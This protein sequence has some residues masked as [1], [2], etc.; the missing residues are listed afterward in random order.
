MPILSEQPSHYPDDL[1][2]E[3]FAGHPGRQWWV[4]YTKVRQEKAVAR[5]FLKLRTPFY[6]P[7]VWKRSV[8]RGRVIRSQ[9]PLFPGYVF[10]Y[11]SEEE[12]VASLATNRIVRI[13]AV[14]APER[15]REDLS[16][17]RRLIASGAAVTL[18][19]RLEPG[20]RVRVRHGPFVGIEGTVLTR[21][22]ATRLLVAVDFLQQG[23]SIEIDDA[24][25]EPVD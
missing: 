19:S 14:V 18:E 21:R 23:A 3:S 17:L 16:R 11:G 5:Q 20:I 13:L 7:L 15:L 1:L 24:V 8:T 25:L 22:G 4:L 6:L 9:L 12:R 10:L 2:H